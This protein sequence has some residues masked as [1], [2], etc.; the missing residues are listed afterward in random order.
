MRLELLHI[1]DCPNIEATWRLLDETLR[2]LGLVEEIR[3]IEVSDS[4]QA[5]APVALCTN[6]LSIAAT[7]L[8]L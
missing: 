4:S 5:D 7:G 2:E 3:E 8:L 6:Q 1:A